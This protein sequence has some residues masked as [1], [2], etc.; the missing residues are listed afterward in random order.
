MIAKLTT[1]LALTMDCSINWAT[2]KAQ[3]TEME[4]PTAMWIH[5][6]RLKGVGLTSAD[7]SALGVSVY[8]WR[9]IRQ[10]EPQGGGNE[11]LDNPTA[12]PTH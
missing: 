8:S 7:A 1:R 6:A 11:T 12:M 2:R 3:Q 10:A 4:T 5:S 9:D